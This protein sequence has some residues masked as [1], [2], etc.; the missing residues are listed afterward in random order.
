MSGSFDCIDMPLAPMGC[1]LKVHD[2]TE[3]R[4]TWEF[5]SLNGWYIKMSPEHYFTQRCSIK[6]TRSKR[7]R[8]TVQFQHKKITNHTITHGEKII[9]TISNCAKALQD[10]GDG[11]GKQE[12][13]DLRKLVDST[14][15]AIQRDPDFMEREAPSEIQPVT[16]SVPRVQ[17]VPRVQEEPDNLYRRVTR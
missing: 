9:H 12:M 6:S 10:L 11:M 4:G 5:H 13:I 17:P 7:I 15:K 1:Q 16:P 8:N 3:K 14:K 2:K